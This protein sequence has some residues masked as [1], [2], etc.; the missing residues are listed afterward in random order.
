M[1][2][3]CGA[4]GTLLWGLFCTSTRQTSSP[5]PEGPPSLWCCWDLLACAD[6]DNPL[7]PLDPTCFPSPRAPKQDALLQ[8]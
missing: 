7:Q 6:W 5:Q 1:E 8:F 3:A 2:S 4:P